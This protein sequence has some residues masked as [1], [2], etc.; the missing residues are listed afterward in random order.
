[1]EK[2]NKKIT[3]DLLIGFVFRFLLWF[4]MAKY[5]FFE[6][7]D[8]IAIMLSA[9]GFAICLTIWEVFGILRERKKNS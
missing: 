2:G 4:L 9:F 5:L 1:M 3:L 6:K 8:T 7:K